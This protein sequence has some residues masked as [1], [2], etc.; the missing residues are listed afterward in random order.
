[1]SRWFSVSIL[2]VLPPELESLGFLE[3]GSGSE[4]GR[5]KYLEDVTSVV[6]RDVS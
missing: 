6:R 1:M 3:S 2:S 4:E 5:L